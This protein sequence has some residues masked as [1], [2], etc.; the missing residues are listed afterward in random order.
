M[1]LLSELADAPGKCLHHFDG[2][3]FENFAMDCCVLKVI[4]IIELRKFAKLLQLPKFFNAFVTFIID[5]F[6]F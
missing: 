2:F 5:N 3:V 6:I 4:S 1:Y